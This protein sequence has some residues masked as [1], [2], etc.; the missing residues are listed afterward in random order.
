M[1]MK[2]LKEIAIEAMEKFNEM[3]CVLYDVTSK[4]KY[5]IAGFKAIQ[6]HL[7]EVR[8][9]T[10]LKKSRSAAYNNIGEAVLPIEI[11]DEAETFVYLNIAVKTN[12][13]RVP[14]TSLCKESLM[15]ENGIAPVG[16][17]VLRKN[18]E[19][20]L[21]CFAQI[22]F[23]YW[24]KHEQDEMLEELVK[25]LENVN[26]DKLYRDVRAVGNTWSG[27][28]NWYIKPT[29]GYTGIC[30]Y[31]TDFNDEK[32]FLLE[33]D[34]RLNSAIYSKY[35]MS[36]LVNVFIGDNVVPQ[37]SLGRKSST[38]EEIIFPSKYLHLYKL[39]NEN[40]KLKRQKR[41]KNAKKGTVQERITNYS[42]LLEPIEIE[43]REEDR[44][45]Y[46]Y[47]SRVPLDDVECVALRFFR[48]RYNDGTYRE[49][50]RIFVEN[51]KLTFAENMDGIW[52]TTRASLNYNFR[53]F[54]IA[55]FEDAV[56]KGTKLE[57]LKDMITEIKE[58]NKFNSE[59][60]IEVL[61]NN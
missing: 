54:K 35:L 58:V 55:P 47:L 21:Y 10:L 40:V 11:E 4:G 5:A 56:L 41:A 37:C 53:Y 57:Y 17:T 26:Y 20:G 61:C 30:E 19:D 60:L 34:A 39:V 2:N 24:L 28:E 46:V 38:C 33:S 52:I 44:D 50:F 59:E 15:N 12:S 14:D 8:N 1:N 29:Y 18:P 31:V 7:C 36:E 25:D 6:D 51:S 49:A 48:R 9:R 3:N 16:M 23:A 27:T 43:I 32:W 42:E 22:D 13:P 45:D